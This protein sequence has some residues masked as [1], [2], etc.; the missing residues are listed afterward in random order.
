MS[1]QDQ[2]ERE[3]AEICE[4]YNRGELTMKQYNEAINDLNREY[5]GMMEEACQNAY[6]NERSNW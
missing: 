5:S 4:M 3:E 1:I 2:F 6:D